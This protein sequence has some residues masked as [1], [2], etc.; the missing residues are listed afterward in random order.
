MEWER[1]RLREQSGKVFSGWRGQEPF[2]MLARKI[3]NARAIGGQEGK[4]V[5]TQPETD[6]ARDKGGVRERVAGQRGGVAD[7]RCAR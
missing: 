7:G 3:P 6:T 5:E 1:S 2:W 4:Q